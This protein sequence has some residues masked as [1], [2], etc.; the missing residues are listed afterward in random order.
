MKILFSA[1]WHIRLGQK[2]VPRDFQVS[3]FNMLVEELNSIYRKHNCDLHIIGGD[4]LDRFAP[5]AEEIE[6]Y[7]EL[8]AKLE[9]TTQVFCG[10][11]ELINK[12]K[13][14]LDTMKAE[15]QRCNPKVEIV[16]SL[17][18]EEY[19]I[20]DFKELHNKKWTPA[21]SKLC[22][23]HVRGAIPPHVLPE[24]DLDLFK[25]YT[26]VVT[27]DLHSHQCT[28]ESAG[29][30]PFIYPGSPLSTSF[31]RGER[32]VGAHGVLIVDTETL[33][34]EHVCLEKLPQ[35]LRKTIEAG[36]EMVADTYDRVIYEVTGDLEDLKGVED[37]DLLDKRIHKNVGT[38][39]T[40][41]L[42]SNL[43][44]SEELQMYL[45]EVERLDSDKV[46]AALSAFKGLVNE[47]SY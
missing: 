15:T 20:I 14:V 43:K 19:D 42:G 28:Q 5:S 9:H 46:Q 24:V 23:T 6:L 33:T 31:S 39:A 35:L 18:T 17:R 4:I 37:S 3:R 44:I 7:Y 38:E 11:H 8:I 30:I 36:E 16:D 13:S 27:G 21:E 45:S 34:Y 47:D 1:D 10:N 2:N 40:L 26:L 32:S 22:F 12:K 29:G 25:A 41:E